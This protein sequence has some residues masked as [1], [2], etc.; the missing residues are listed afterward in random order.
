MWVH[1]VITPYLYYITFHS[2]GV[3]AYPMYFYVA[4][5]GDMP[6]LFRRIVLQVRCAD[7]L[8]G[9]LQQHL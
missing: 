1:H 5:A 3:W 4:A 9:A 7:V 2:M 8:T 6:C